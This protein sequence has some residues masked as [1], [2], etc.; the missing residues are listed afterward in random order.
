MAEAEAGTA[1]AEAT[2]V[3]V[4]RRLLELRGVTGVD[5]RPDSRI[6]D[7]LDLDSLELAELSAA[8]ED[9]LG[10]D[11]YTE[12]LVPRT[13]GELVAYYAT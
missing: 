6:R 1:E 4:I 2:I 10:R 9:E 7:D 11:P 8:L 12:G 13:V 5:I 3:G